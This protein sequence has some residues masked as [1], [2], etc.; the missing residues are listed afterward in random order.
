MLFTFG[1]DWLPV[2]ETGRSSIGTSLQ[3]K[4]SEN[5][6]DMMALSIQ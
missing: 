3:G 1:A 5:F 4:S 6:A 2:G